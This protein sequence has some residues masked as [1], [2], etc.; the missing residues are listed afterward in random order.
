[1]VESHRSALNR[2][3]HEGVELETNK[4]DIILNSK[5]ERNH[6]RIPRIMIEVGDEVEE[7][8]SSG[9]IRSTEMGGK[10]RKRGGMNVKKVGKRDN[11]ETTREGK[12]GERRKVEGGG[13]SE[14]QRHET[15]EVEK[16]RGVREREKKAKTVEKI[17]QR[18]I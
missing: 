17:P 10:E 1:M 11:D 18:G 13:S 9:M 2:Q 14:R 4:A 15:K 7:D 16:T 12:E 8:E 3:I 6:C 5:S